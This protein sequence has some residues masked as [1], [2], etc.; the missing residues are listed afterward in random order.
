MH[1]SEYNDVVK[2][3]IEEVFRNRGVNAEHTLKCCRD[4]EQYAKEA[5][6][7]KLLGFA[8]YYSGETYYGL[9]DGENLFRYI[10][11]AITYLD[12][13]EQWELMAKA[14]NIMA[15][16]SSNRGNAP[17][18]MDYYLTGL[19]YCKKYNIPNIEAILNLNLGTLYMVYGQYREALQYFERSYQYFKSHPEQDQYKSC[20]ICIYMSMGKCYMLRDMLDKAQE[21]NELLDKECTEELSSIDWLCILCFKVTLYH[22]M[23][24]ISLRDQMIEEI[25]NRISDDFAIMDIFDD[26]HDLCSL[27]LELERK[28]VFWD[29]I[30]ILEELTKRAKIINLERRIIALKLRYYRTEHDNAGYL[31]AA[32]L[33]YELTERMERE[34]H[35]M[36]ASMIN[37][38][39]SLELANERRRTVEEANE[40]LQ[41]KSETDQLT[42]LANRYRLNDYS[43]KV[44]ERCLGAHVPFAVEILDIDYF[45]QYND[46]YGHQAGD[47]CILAI[48]KEMKKIQNDQIFCARYGGDEF[49]IIY[50]DMSE[51]EVLKVADRLRSNIVNLNMEHRYSKALPVVTISQGICYDIPYAESKNWDYLHTADMMLYRVKKQSR[52]NICLGSLDEGEICG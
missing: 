52:N 41:K 47:E 50:E 26:L 8:Y 17:I 19:N 22:R 36:I 31:Q 42:G 6:D 32:G 25:H 3:W 45:K 38:R 24:R 16:T 46:N 28:E 1:F 39:S 34:N 30:Q 12:Q 5:N 7:A 13:S 49:I 20:I 27:L 18:A 14:Y 33:Y 35:Y 15:I 44:F 10:T 29:I 11:K 21:Y 48:A 43:E 9:N 23:G 4:I 2:A 40:R 37:V 51:E